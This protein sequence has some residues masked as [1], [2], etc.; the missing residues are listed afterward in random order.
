MLCFFAILVPANFNLVPIFAYQTS[1]FFVF[2]HIDG[3]G[4][5]SCSSATCEIIP[6]IDFF[7]KDC[8][9][10]KRQ[11]HFQDLGSQSHKKRSFILFKD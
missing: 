7:I 1:L 11:R 5:R 4:I 8:N 3:T 9:V 6:T 10:S 2:K